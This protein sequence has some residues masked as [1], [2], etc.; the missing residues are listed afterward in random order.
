MEF[1]PELDD[2]PLSGENKCGWLYGSCEEKAVWH[3]QW[4]MDGQGA[5]CMLLCPEHMDDINSQYVYRERHRAGSDCDVP[6]TR[7]YSTECK[8]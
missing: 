1:Q 8:L 4:S 5:H 3:V 2:I 7:W 6:G